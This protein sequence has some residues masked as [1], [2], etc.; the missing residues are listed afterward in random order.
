MHHRRDFIEERCRGGGG[1]SASAL[2]V[3]WAQVGGDRVSRL[4]RLWH[5]GYHLLNIAVD[6]PQAE[7]V[8]VADI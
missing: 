3:A 5:R 7:V 8:A 1:L 2:T 6:L 4:A